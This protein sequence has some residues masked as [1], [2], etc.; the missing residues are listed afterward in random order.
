[1]AKSIKREEAQALIEE[2]TE[3]GGGEGL[4]KCS[5]CGQCVALCPPRFVDNKYRYTRF[6]RMIKLGLRDDII[7]DV[8][9]WECT[10]CNRCTEFCPKG[11]KPFNTIV[12]LRRLQAK[13]LA[14]PMSSF[15]GVMGIL[16]NGHG[17][18]SKAGKE[19]RKKVGLPENPPS[20][21][22][23]PEAIEEIKTILSHT[24]LVDMGIL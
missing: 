11:A 2:I 1:M 13:E 3:L 14:I 20:A 9:P 7:D 4:R 21:I 16:K 10:F 19:L 23:Y 15:E 6:I 24:K 18:I 8:T 5:S 12:A 17:V 22:K